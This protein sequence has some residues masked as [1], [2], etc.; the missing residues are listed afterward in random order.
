[1]A[2]PPRLSLS[3][4][5]SVAAPPQ[6]CLRGLHG[7]VS[8]QG[9]ASTT[10]PTRQVAPAPS[11][12]LYAPSPRHGTASTSP[13]PRNRLRGTASTAPPPCL[14]LRGSTSTALPQRLCL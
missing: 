4:S 6:L 3:A 13:A 2:L 7:Y 12:R 11:P 5:A 8:N 14:R 10:P 1:M 9:S